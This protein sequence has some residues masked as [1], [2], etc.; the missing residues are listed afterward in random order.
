MLNDDDLTK[1]K[2]TIPQATELRQCA[3]D[4]FEERMWLYTQSAPN[5][6]KSIKASGS[7]SYHPESTGHVAMESSGSTC[8]GRYKD[9][10]TLPL[11]P[12]T[13]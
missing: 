8:V 9:D 10:L 3:I 13:L 11:N 12:P 4:A 5:N 7:A 6:G 2:L 1:A